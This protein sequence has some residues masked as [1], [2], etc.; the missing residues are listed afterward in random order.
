MHSA[1]ACRKPGGGVRERHLLNQGGGEASAGRLRG[2]GYL[3]HHR[4]EIGEMK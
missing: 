3:R 2:D 1:D 4:G